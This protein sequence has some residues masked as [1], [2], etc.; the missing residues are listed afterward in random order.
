MGGSRRS[1]KLDVSFLLNPPQSGSSSN[2]NSDNP[3]GR[4]SGQGGSASRPRPER[5][6]STSAG[7]G[8]RRFRCESCSA[9]FAQSH[10]ALKHKRFVG[11]TKQPLSAPDCGPQK[12]NR[13]GV[14]LTLCPVQLSVDSNR[15]VHEKLRPYTC[16]ICGKSFGEKGKYCVPSSRVGFFFLKEVV[17][18]LLTSLMVVSITGKL[19]FFL[20]VVVVGNLSKHKKSVH[21]NERPFSC[22]YCSSSFAFKDGL[23]R[24]RS[25]VHYDQRPF[26]CS[27]CGADFK[28]ISQLRKHSCHPSGSS[29]SRGRR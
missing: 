26:V 22:E 6:T 9:T 2:N 18:L 20:V 12:S 28:Q 25:L 3:F 11:N 1:P 7:S 13:R 10:D 15:T 14:E 24:H 21:L 5:R 17:T 19:I 16:D 23:Q 4:S 29:S 8:Q 27:H